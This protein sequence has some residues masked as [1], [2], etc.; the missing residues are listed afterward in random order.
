MP[1]PS[2]PHA[3][4]W[5]LDATALSG[6]LSRGE[7]S[8]REATL[9]CLHR[10]KEYGEHGKALGAF[11]EVFHEQ[12]LRD[13]DAADAARKR[14]EARSPLHGVP[15]SVKECFDL[16]GKPTTLGIPSRQGTTATEDAALVTLL[17]EAGGVVIGRTN[18]PQL[19]LSYESRNPIWGPV[20]NPWDLGRTPGG[21]S[22]G[23]SAALAA[24]CSFLGLGSDL[25]GSIRVPAH[26][27][28]TAGL[29]P[30]LDRWPA[31]GCQT[32]IPGQ[33]ATRGMPG[34]MARTSRDVALWMAAIDLVKASRL[35]GRVPPLPFTDPARVDLSRLRVGVV[36]P[37]PFF[38]A[39]STAV[40]RAVDEAAAHLRAAGC[41]VVPFAAPEV[42]ETY[43][44][45]AAAISADGG[46][47][48]SRALAGGARDVVIETLLRNFTLGALTRKLAA[49]MMRRGGDPRVALVLEKL[50]RRPVD[51]FFALT[52]ATRAA[53]QR[54]LDAMAKEGIDLLLLPPF[55]TPAPQ[56]T[57]SKDCMPAGAYSLLFNVLQLPAGVAPVTC[58][59]PGEEPRAGTSRL[60]RLAAAMDA[61][62]A[63]LPVGVQVVGRPWEES[64]VLA[65]MIAIEDAARRVP[66][67]PATPLAP[68]AP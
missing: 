15:V 23:E 10:I 39:P 20:N 55:A 46:A 31:R 25:G 53:R 4:L 35:D 57:T 48:I 9:A 65:A 62:S 56:H 24:G 51:A 64:N 44:L 43:A 18:I 34:P 14:G 36:D 13:A 12:A 5:S 17:R 63:G 3:Q 40:Q 32:G 6:L 19:L 26:F 59:Q 38:L 54:F 60:E 22:G 1:A 2:S 30:T 29:K 7:V 67:F 66:G 49:G 61:G 68:R 50:G 42:V 28:G 37:G 8:S 45:Q 47:V 27:T 11:T 52:A 33:E 16:R 41:A 58:V 21:S